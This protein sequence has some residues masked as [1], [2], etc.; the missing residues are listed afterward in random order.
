MAGFWGERWI[1]SANKVA[2]GARFRSVVNWLTG[3]I[4][5]DIQDTT[6]I[7]RN[8][9]GQEIY[10]FSVVYE[11]GH[12]VMKKGM[13]L[14]LVILTTCNQYTVKGRCSRIASKSSRL[15]SKIT[16]QFLKI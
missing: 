8:F 7:V 10:Q 15:S 12:A 14:L 5:L 13:L 6:T 16:V 3:R 11:F 4:V 1:I 9:N 2:N